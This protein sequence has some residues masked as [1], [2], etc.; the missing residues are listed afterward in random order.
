MKKGISSPSSVLLG[1]VLVRFMLETE[2]LIDLSEE[3]LKKESVFSVV[4]VLIGAYIS[5]QTEL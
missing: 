1:T 4:M 2:P 5:V 3:H